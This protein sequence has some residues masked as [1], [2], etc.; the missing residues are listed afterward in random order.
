MTR[1]KKHLIIT[2]A[3][4]RTQRGRSKATRESRFL[5]EIPEEFLRLLTSEQP[6]STLFSGEPV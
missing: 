6:V 5:D 2:T 1:A 4:I 3:A